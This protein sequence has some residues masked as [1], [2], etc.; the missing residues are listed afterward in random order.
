MG[1]SEL[2]ERKASFSVFISL[3]NA[4]ISS[5]DISVV[6]NGCSTQKQLLK[7]KARHELSLRMP[8]C[9]V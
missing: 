7:W 2:C 6:I 4:G 3:R 1:N 8:G 5:Q 9:W